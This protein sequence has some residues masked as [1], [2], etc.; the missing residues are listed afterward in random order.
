MTTIRNLGQEEEK[1]IKESLSISPAFY[2]PGM[3]VTL[4]NK[5]KF[6]INNEIQNY[7]EK[8]LIED[9]DL[10]VLKTLFTYRYLTAYTLKCIILNDKTIL[11]TC[12]RS[13]YKRRLSKLVSLGMALR[14]RIRYLDEDKIEHYTPCYYTLSKSSFDYTARLYSAKISYG[15]A[16]LYPGNPSPEDLIKGV[17]FNQFHAQFI[18]IYRDKL[19]NTYLN[20]IIKA[21]KQKTSLYALYQMA[22]SIVSLKRID[23]I[24]IPVRKNPNYKK[25]LLNTF[26]CISEYMKKDS[27]LIKQPVFIL[28]CED[29]SH[30]REV[31]HLINQLNHPEP[32]LF[33]VDCSLLSSDML[34]KLFLVEELKNG[35]YRLLLQKLAF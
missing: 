29:G 6:V 26:S 16:L 7:V 4:E 14:Y 21:G 5:K 18:S 19:Q 1:S 11:E 12:K 24:C 17:V 32:V 35:D 15:R 31:N 22:T 10:V 33:T 9:V 13:N 2:H 30:A 34:E 27:A 28:I 23:L 20:L 8:G 25:E 3:Q